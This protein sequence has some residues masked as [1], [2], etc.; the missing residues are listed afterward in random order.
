MKK[1]LPFLFLTVFF[2]GCT[3]KYDIN[4][5]N[6]I[7][8]KVQL[9]ISKQIVTSSN[10]TEKEFVD[11]NFHAYD[12]L[13]ESKKYVKTSSTDSKNVYM[14]IERVYHDFDEFKNSIAIKT[15]FPTIEKTERK[16]VVTLKFSGL[17]NQEVFNDT[18]GSGVPLDSLEFN[19]HTDYVV[20]SSNAD[21]ID[22]VNNI[23]T[24]KFNKKSKIDEI[25]L[26]Y[27]EEIYTP[28]IFAYIKKYWSVALGIV[29]LLLGS[30]ILGFLF[31]KNRRNNQL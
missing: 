31:Q 1:L 10:M 12:E 29:F 27:K 23:Y 2:T 8:E 17:L 21:K 19:I 15:F 3:V 28:N 20:E 26:S 18:I 6:A 5:D 11:M 24:W 16:D 30:L 7:E 13:E 9:E 4:L 14:N 22:E 25:F